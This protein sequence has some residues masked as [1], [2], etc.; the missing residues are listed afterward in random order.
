MSRF[1]KQVINGIV[2]GKIDLQVCKIDKNRL[3]D[4]Q[5]HPKSSASPSEVIF[6]NLIDYTS[7]GDQFKF[8][9]SMKIWLDVTGVPC[10]YLKQINYDSTDVEGLKYE[11]DVYKNIINKI[12]SSDESPN[13]IPFIGYGECLLQDICKHIGKNNCKRLMDD[14]D[15]YYYLIMKKYPQTRLCIMMTYR[16]PDSKSLNK[17]L[18]PNAKSLEKLDEIGNKFQN[19]EENLEFDRIEK[20]NDVF[21]Q[22]IRKKINDGINNK[23]HRLRKKYRKIE[24]DFYRQHFSKI[25]NTQ[26]GKEILFQIVYSLAVMDKYRLVHHDLHIGN[27]LIRKYKNLFKRVYEIN[28]KKYLIQTRYQPYIFDWDLAYSEELG[29]NMKLSTHE[30]KKNNIR[31]KYDNRF[32]LY[33]IFCILLFTGIGQKYNNDISKL[34][35]QSR[36]LRINKEIYEKIGK[37]NG[38]IGRDELELMGLEGEKAMIQI[39]KDEN[40]KGYYLVKFLGFHCRPTFEDK[41]LPTAKELLNTEYFDT[42]IIDDIPNNIKS[43]YHIKEK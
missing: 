24:D 7:S 30:Y 33:V 20:L 40:N 25:W 6:A 34:K 38:T 14:L 2:S 11:L 15:K 31:N 39:T 26:T 32:D 4:V 9:I 37:K 1:L 10:W 18:Q 36:M 22:T 3:R 16:P 17:M 41:N 29:D 13:F 5:M 12:I 43:F 23:I 35:E 19:D 42:L 21:D 28:G 8:P 27:I